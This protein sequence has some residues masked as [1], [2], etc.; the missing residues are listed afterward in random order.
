MYTSVSLLLKQCGG[1]KEN[2]NQ[3][4]L[5]QIPELPYI[6][7]V[8]NCPIIYYTK[9]MVSLSRQTC[10]S[11]PVK[12]Y[13]YIFCIFLLQSCQIYD[14]KH[15][16]STGKGHVSFPRERLLHPDNISNKKKQKK[17]KKTYTKMSKSRL[18]GFD[19]RLNWTK[20]G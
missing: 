17:T 19:I 9:W 16:I 14:Y 1:S 3:A 4:N 8:L 20:Y 11:I 12:H 2:I 18:W 13:T 5:A 6:N 10:L 7:I 15:R